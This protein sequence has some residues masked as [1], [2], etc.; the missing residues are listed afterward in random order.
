MILNE[1]FFPQSSKQ[2][3]QGRFSFSINSLSLNSYLSNVVDGWTELQVR[4]EDVLMFLFGLDRSLMMLDNM[5][6]VLLVQR[7]PGHLAEERVEEGE[8]GEGVLSP[9]HSNPQ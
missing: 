7:P 1:N 8:G 3:R 6:V 5:M 9:A 4:P 2:E